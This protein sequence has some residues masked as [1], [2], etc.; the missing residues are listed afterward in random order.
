MRILARHERVIYHA[1]FEGYEPV[2]DNNGYETGEVTLKY[3]VAKLVRVGVS[4]ATN[5][6]VEY[7]F[8]SRVECDLILLTCDTS[9]PIAEKSALWIDNLDVYGKHD[10]E[11]KKIVKSFNTIAIAVSKVS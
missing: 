11:V 7:L 3:G 2:L 9:C 1:P 4:V 6:N 5:R 8:G 10:Y